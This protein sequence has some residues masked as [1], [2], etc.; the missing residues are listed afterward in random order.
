MS[1]RNQ[2]LDVLRGFAILLVMGRHFDY[3][4]TWR[5]IGWSG[6]DLFFV[7][8]GYLI[9]G[10]LFR[11]FSEFGRIRVTRFLIR[12]GFKIWP[13]LY[14]FL[15]V[16]SLLLR[17]AGGSPKDVWL[18]AAFVRNYFM[19]PDGSFLFGHTWSL[20]VE[21]HFY[22]LLPFVLLLLTRR[23]EGLQAI[24]YI[25]GALIV[26]C[27]AL[28]ILLHPVQTYA[29][30]FRLDGLFAGV[31]LRYVHDFRAEW[32]RK[33]S[34]HWAIPAATVLLAPVFLFEADSRAMQTWGLTAMLA[35]FALLVAWSVDRKPYAWL[36]PLAAIGVFSYSIYLWQQP[37]S[38]VI[39]NAWGDSA[40]TFSFY[41]VV[42]IAFGVLMAKLIEFPALRLRDT[43]IG[44]STNEPHEAN[45]LRVIN[46]TG[47][48][49]GAVWARPEDR[50]D[51]R[52][53]SRA[54]S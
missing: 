14:V 26:A 44:E 35:G 41:V 39:R 17:W 36:R 47:R 34:G 53:A 15:L 48:V 20:C 45:Q 24:P 12:R 1:T 19:A 13:P 5:M 51:S 4:L 3:C 23:R 40:F 21:E 2:S 54:A 46:P 50:A 16:V 29:T 38:L 42:A 28:R 31:C 7:L 10:L 52:H 22:F 49:G 30:H 6:V 33:V 9:S 37:I 43:L 25:S 8:S 27:L 32:F 11:D 18:S